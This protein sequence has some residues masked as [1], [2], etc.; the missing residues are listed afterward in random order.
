MV[1]VV[2]DEARPS[3]CRKL[4]ADETIDHTEG[5][6]APALRKIRADEGLT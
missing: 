2:S 1:A 3:F 4:G 5:P 6:V